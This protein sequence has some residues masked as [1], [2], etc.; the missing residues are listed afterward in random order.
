[1]AEK[2]LRSDSA[3]RQRQVKLATRDGTATGCDVPSA[4]AGEGPTDIRSA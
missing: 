2:E 3:S 4:V 1:M